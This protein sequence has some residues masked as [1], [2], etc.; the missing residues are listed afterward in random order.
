MKKYI[1]KITLVISTMF[2]LMIFSSCTAEDPSPISKQV[3]DV[4]D[5]DRTQPN[6]IEG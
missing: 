2:V 3:Q 5:I 4:G 6:K 1:A